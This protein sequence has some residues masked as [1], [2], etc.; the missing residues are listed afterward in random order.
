MNTISQ[1]EM[2]HPIRRLSRFEGIGFTRGILFHS[3][4][5]SKCHYTLDQSVF[6]ALQITC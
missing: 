3:P 2:T 5:R 4:N 1:G 6:D